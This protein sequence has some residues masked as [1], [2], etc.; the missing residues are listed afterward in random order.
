MKRLLLAL[1]LFSFISTSQAQF[2]RG[3]GFKLGSTISNQDW[4]YVPSLNITLDSD[5]RIGLNIGFFAEL[6]NNPILSIV[7]EL[8]YVQKGM[9]I[10]L[11]KTTVSNP[12]GT[13]E[14]F[15]WDT[16]ID[17]INLSAL[18]KIRLDLGIV[19]PYVIAGP[20]IDFEINKVFS[21][22]EANIVEDNFNKNRIGFKVGIGAEIKLMSLNLL[23]EILYDADFNELYE[24]EN[25]KV[26][27]NSIDFR[28]GLML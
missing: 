24:N 28:V 7:T 26:N 8:N 23:A 20:K 22:N 15:T 4:E 6:L 16:R 17:Y 3:Y 25:L 18:G 21:L 10:D 5:N 13:G 14:F 12:D 9:K 27:S 1:I 19:S 2:V 11:Q